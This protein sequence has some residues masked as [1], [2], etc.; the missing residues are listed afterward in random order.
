MRIAVVSTYYSPNMGYTEN[1][2]PAALARLGH[3]VHVISSRLNVYGNSPDYDEN[4]RAFLGPAEVAAGESTIDGY[5]L[6]RLEH[7]L[8]AGYVGLRGIRRLLGTLAPDVVHSTAVASL[9]SYAIASAPRRPF[10]FYTE[11]HQHLSVV[12]PYLR[13]SSG[14]RVK[15]AMFWLTR[16]VP[17][18]FVGRASSRCFAVAPDC[19]QVAEQLYGVP[20]EKIEIQSLGTDTT[21]FRPARDA[22]DVARRQDARAKL[23]Y[24]DDDI[25]VLYTG[26]FTEAKNP[27]VLAD[28]ID[29]LAAAGAPFQGLFVGEGAQRD[30]IQSRRNCRVMNF[31]PH[32]QLPDLYRTADIAAWPRQESMSMLDA[33]ASGLPIIVSSSIGERQ[34]VRGNGAFYEENDVDDLARVLRTMADAT[35]RRRLGEAGR[36]LMEDEFSWDAIARRLEGIYRRDAAPVATR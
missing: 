12:K 20:R 30:A 16:T 32:P 6:H 22:G 33:A 3:D 19:A 2:L 8:I 34:R 23:G 11:C 9:A 29:R 7:R 15:R 10:R 1:C 13:N 36:R 17:G 25:I 31:V 27:L 18:T 28:A 26:R 35:T 14:H 5:T 4:Y 21:L 24:A